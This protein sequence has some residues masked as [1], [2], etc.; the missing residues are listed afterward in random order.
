MKIGD[1][2]ELS[3]KGRNLKYCKEFVGLVGV[4]SGLDSSKNYQTREWYYVDWC[5]GKKNAP[6]LRTDLKF[7]S[8]R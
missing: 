6:H 7:V 8:R 3:A 1:L 5:G 2:V 4:I